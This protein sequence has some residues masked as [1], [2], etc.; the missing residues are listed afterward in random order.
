MVNQGEFATLLDE[1]K[2]LN[3]RMDKTEDR[4]QQRDDESAS[5]GTI[6]ASIQQELKERESS[7]Q[8]RSNQKEDDLKLADLPSFDGNDDANAYL[9]WERRMDRVFDYKK[10]SDSR[11]FDYAILKLARYASLCKIERQR[12]S[13]PQFSKP[14]FT[15]KQD[16]STATPSEDSIDDVN[17]K[18][19]EETVQGS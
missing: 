15:S 13:K 4:L 7:P 1:F 2:K 19:V 18:K 9:D 8:P 11:R 10:V 12:E 16:I 6:L 5:I 17:T 14:N 3:A